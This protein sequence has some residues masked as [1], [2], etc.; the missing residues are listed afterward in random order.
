MRYFVGFSQPNIVQLITLLPLVSVVQH[1]ITIMKIT[2]ILQLEKFNSM[3]ACLNHDL[4]FLL[5]MHT[6]NPGSELVHCDA[7]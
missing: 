4:I 1:C 7:L 6:Y 2:R 5:S 3:K